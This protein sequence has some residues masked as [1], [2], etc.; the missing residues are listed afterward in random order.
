MSDAPDPIDVGDRRELFVDDHLID[1]FSGDARL[2]LHHP[3]REEI[4]MTLDRPWEGNVSLYAVIVPVNDGYRLYYRGW[5]ID[6]GPGGEPTDPVT[7]LARSPDGLQWERVDV[8]RIPFDGSTDNNIVWDGIGSSTFTPFLDGNPEASPDA[9]YKAVAASKPEEGSR[10]LYAFTS[11]DGIEWQSAGPILDQNHISY[12]AFDSQNVAFW[13][14]VREEYRVYVRDWALDD[15]TRRIATATSTDFLEWTNAEFIDLEPENDVPEHL[16]TNAVQPY[17]RAPHIMV[18]FPAR[19]RPDRG[20]MVEPLFMASR[21]GHT[22]RRYRDALIRPGRNADRWGNRSNYVQTG[23]M[24]TPSPL[25]GEEQELS[26]LTNEGYYEGED[27]RF[28]R[29]SYRLDG[30][31]SLHAP[32]TGGEVVTTPIVFEGQQLHLNVSTAVSGHVRVEVQEAD[33]TPIDGFELHDMD[34]IY[35]DELDH[36]VS[37]RGADG[38]S[39]LAGTP[40]RLRFEL[41]DADVF[42]MRFGE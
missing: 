16:Y 36:P 22:F 2:T 12:K 31:V 14:A 13:D 33:G 39:D 15:T 18:G 25:P 38:L 41:K 35:G 23:L 17:P 11:P 1:S 34:D 29:Y 7:C 4:A 30:F 27:T 19:F 6:G 5:H 40:I 42:A 9:R 10:Q 32:A 8:G 20:D 37:W 3:R 24:L 21:D 26:I 28:R